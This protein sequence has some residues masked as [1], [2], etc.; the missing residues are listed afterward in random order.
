[1]LRQATGQITRAANDAVHAYRRVTAGLQAEIRRGDTDPAEAAA[2]ERALSEA[3]AEMLNALEVASQRYPW[4][5]PWAASAEEPSE[6][7]AE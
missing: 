4:A 1:M 2:M 6:G 5:K 3:R 7:A